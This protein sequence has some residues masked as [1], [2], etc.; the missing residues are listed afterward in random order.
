MAIA[1]ERVTGSRRKSCGTPRQRLSGLDLVVL[2]GGFSYGDYL[3]CGAMAAQS[4]V[5]RAVR[6]LRRRGRPCARRL[7]RLP[8]PHRSRA[9][10]RRV[11]AQRLAAV[12]LDGLL[13]AGR[14]RRHGLHQPLSARANFAH[15]GA[16]R[17]QLLRRR[18]R[19]STGWR[20]TIW[21]P[22]AMRRR[23]ARSRRR[24]TATAGPRHRRH[25]T[26]PICGCSA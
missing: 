14:A 26:A 9:A 2:P 21:S 20:A 23:A 3:R 5:M 19:R 24:R 25:P 6:A 1:L 18:R 15:H 17:R 8:D 22:S 12:P 7:Q 16:R 4:P 10:A 13:S 11:A